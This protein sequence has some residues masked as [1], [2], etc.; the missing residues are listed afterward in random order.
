MVGDHVG[1]LHPAPLPVSLAKSSMC[2]H[3]HRSSNLTRDLSVLFAEVVAQ[4]GIEP[5]TARFLLVVALATKLLLG[6]VACVEQRNN[7][8]LPRQHNEE[9]YKKVMTAA[10]TNKVTPLLAE[11]LCCTVSNCYVSDHLYLSRPSAGRG[12]RSWR[13]MIPRHGART[14]AR[15]APCRRSRTT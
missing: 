10:C 1:T 6:R 8:T 15:R 12:V 3:T 7:G 13:W 11:P 2:Q 4:L 14:P 9:M 5:T